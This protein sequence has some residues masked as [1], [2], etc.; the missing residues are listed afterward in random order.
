MAKRA[1]MDVEVTAV[2]AEEVTSAMTFADAMAGQLEDKKR[3]SQVLKRVCHECPLGAA[4]H[5]LKRVKVDQDTGQT[6]VLV[7]WDESRCEAVKCL[8]PG[9]LMKVKVPTKPPLTRRQFE[10][11]KRYWPCRFHE[12]KALEDV[13]ARRAEDPWSAAKLAR[14]VHLMCQAEE[15][16]STGCQGAV[17]ASPDAN[18]PMV[19]AKATMDES[20]ALQPVVLKMVDQLA[21]MDRAD[22]SSYLC[23]GLDLYLSHEPCLMSSMALVHAR[24]KRV[25]F[26]QA[27]ADGA[28]ATLTRLHVLP[29]LNHSFEVY[30]FE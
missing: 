6:L 21:A 18:E 22:D 2:L 25:F 30:Q 14:H 13:L 28:L 20:R 23:T 11:A 10:E 3:L 29:Q 16:A 12:D 15:L 9:P 17:L 27:C 24:I 5:F 19:L 4:F 8:F 1:R 26:R 7:H